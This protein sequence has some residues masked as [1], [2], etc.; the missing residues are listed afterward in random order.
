VE[1]TS[2]CDRPIGWTQH[3]TL[4]PPFLKKGVTQFHASAT[5]SRVYEGTFGAADYLAPGADFTWP[6]APDAAGGTIDLTVFTARPQSSAFTTHLMDPTREQAYFAAFTPDLKLAMAYVWQTS[7]FPWLGIWEENL[8]RPS[9]P[10]NGA[11]ITRGMEFGVSPFPETRRQMIDRGR[12]F[13]TPTFRWI[14]A[15]SRVE[16]EYRAVTAARLEDLDT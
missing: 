3:V 1:N 6:L 14:P 5:R 4:G 15:K 10:W 9:A 16:V 11:S 7:D 12:L 8:S 13:D 2:A